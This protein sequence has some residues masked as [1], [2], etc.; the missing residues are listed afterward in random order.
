MGPGPERAHIAPRGPNKRCRAEDAWAL[1]SV[2][3]TSNFILRVAQG[4]LSEAIVLT[5]GEKPDPQQGGTPLSRLFK[6]ENLAHKA[7]GIQA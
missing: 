7:R 2:Q 5:S 1:N 6:L 3:M 4:L